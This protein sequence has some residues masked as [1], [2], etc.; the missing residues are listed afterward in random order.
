MPF[1]T[2]TKKNVQRKFPRWA[3]RRANRH[4]A[5]DN[6]IDRISMMGTGSRVCLATA[7]FPRACCCSH[8]DVY[9]QSMKLRTA[10]GL[11]G[12]VVLARSGAAG[13]F[14]PVTDDPNEASKTFAVISDRNIFHLNPIPIPPPE[15]PKI[16]LPLIKLSGFFR[17]GRHTR[18][19]FCSLPKDKKDEPAYYNLS[20]GE[21][22]GFL[23]LVKIDY[24]KGE[25]EVI[26]SGTRMTLNLK[27]DGLGDK[28]ETASN[29]R[30]SNPAHPFPFHA[31]FQP[32]G[33]S[34]GADNMPFPFRGRSRRSPMPQ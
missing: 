27:D 8:F 19:L 23:E 14:V 2:I 18:A 3:L 7:T 29:L 13:P 25:V 30:G 24:D 34:Q 20:E 5:L 12:C 17:Q 16:E 26:N 4:R 22:S 6:I 10:I 33:F 31:S 15:Q 21:K 28:L 11:L 1:S 9:L 32:P